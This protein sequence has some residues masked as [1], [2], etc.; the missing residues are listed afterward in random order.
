MSV[1]DTLVGFGLDQIS[2]SKQASRSRTA[3]DEAN[4]FTEHM[5][6]HKYQNAIYDLRTAGMNPLLAVGG[7]VSGGGAA[8]AQASPA[9]ANSAKAANTLADG[10]NLVKTKQEIKNMKASEKYTEA[11]TEVQKNVEH[12]TDAAAAVGK[13]LGDAVEKLAGQIGQQNKTPYD[14]VTDKIGNFIKD[15]HEAASAKS[16]QKET[17]NP[18]T[19]KKAKQKFMSKKNMKELIKNRHK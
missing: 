8:G 5:S 1:F 12:V 17:T 6:R 10:L 9:L 15:R 16:V 19:Y 11:Q 14:A 3:A 7:G 4:Q 2:S 18:R 13:H